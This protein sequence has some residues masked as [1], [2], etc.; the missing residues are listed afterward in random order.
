VTTLD[1]V[2]PIIGV[3]HLIV[4]GKL[5]RL[6]KCPFC[7]SLRNVYVEEMNHHVKFTHPGRSCRASDFYPKG[8]QGYSPYITKEEI[9]LPWINCL[10]CDYRDK[11]EFDLSLHFLQEHK[12]GLLA[13]PITRKERLA[14]KALSG[15]WFARFES[16]MEYRLDKA[17]KLAKEKGDIGNA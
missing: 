2:P 12:E 16:P 17:V 11:I 9:K 14:A 15:D 6:L 10:W 13:I 4:N 7:K 5:V 3:T 8:V 1:S